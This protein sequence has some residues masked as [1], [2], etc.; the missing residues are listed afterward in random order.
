MLK[1][2]KSRSFATDWGCIHDD[3]ARAAYVDVVSKEHQN[4]SAKTS[5]LIINPYWPYIGASP[6]GIVE[7]SCCGMRCLEIKCPHSYRNSNP[8]ALIGNDSYICRDSNSNVLVMEDHE[9]YYQM[10]TQ[11]L[12]STLEKCHF[13][14]LTMKDYCL[15]EVKANKI[16]QGE[17][18]TKC[19]L[20]FQNVILQELLSKYFIE[21]KIIP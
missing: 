6:D 5:G 3:E 16:L 11:L 18:V 7:C 1:I 17:I 20:L 9:Y 14:I 21:N 2:N 19:I 12:V 10:Q 4:F 13:F 8:Q 15:I